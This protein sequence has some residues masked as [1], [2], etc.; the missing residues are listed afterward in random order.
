MQLNWIQP[1]TLLKYV[2]VIDVSGL[3]NVTITDAVELDTDGNVTE[4]R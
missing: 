2:N 1:V 3:A 4:I